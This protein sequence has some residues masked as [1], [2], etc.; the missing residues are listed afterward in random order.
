MKLT[1][2]R[3]AGLSVSAAVAGL[4]ILWLAYVRA[5][6][7]IEVC[8]HIIDVTHR[9]SDAVGLAPDT[10]AM[11][12]DS[13]HQRCLQHKHDKIQ[14]RGRIAWARYAKCVLAAEDLRTI[15]RC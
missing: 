8:A 5:P 10:Q 4:A 15:G 6:G 9:E 1:A 12:D 3:A 13:L 14:L 7:P 11:L 2:A